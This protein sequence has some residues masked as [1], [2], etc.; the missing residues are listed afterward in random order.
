[1]IPVYYAYSALP[2]AHALCDPVDYEPLIKLEWRLKHARRGVDEARTRLDNDYILLHHM[3]CG[4]TLHGVEYITSLILD[5]PRELLP[6][7]RGLRRVRFLTDSHLDVRRQ[8]ISMAG[9][10]LSLYNKIQESYPEW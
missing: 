5:K 2:V 3:V 10:Q 7:C 4:L 9:M 8:S 6:L 1:M